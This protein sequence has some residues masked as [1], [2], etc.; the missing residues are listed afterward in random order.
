MIGTEMTPLIWADSTSALIGS[1]GAKLSSMPPIV[2][3]AM[4]P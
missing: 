4:M 1:I 3:S 2:A